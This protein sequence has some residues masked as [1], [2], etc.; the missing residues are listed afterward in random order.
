MQAVR[1]A[2]FW[3]GECGLRQ[4]EQRSRGGLGAGEGW[5]P[6]HAAWLGVRQT[7]STKG[8]Y[9]N[10]GSGG[11]GGNDSLGNGDLESLQVKNSHWGATTSWLRALSKNK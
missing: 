10:A 7:E 9:V 2:A 1:R 4:G 5:G 8:L 6:W 11:S 3:P